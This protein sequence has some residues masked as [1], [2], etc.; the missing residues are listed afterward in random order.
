MKSSTKN[1]AKGKIHLV[2]GK[3][4]ETIGKVVNDRDLE[5]EGKMEKTKGKL[6]GKIAT[7]EKVIEK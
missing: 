1:T 5:L 3:I 4:K 7:I 6:Q 2:K